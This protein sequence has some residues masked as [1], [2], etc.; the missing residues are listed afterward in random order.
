MSTLV[1]VALKIAFLLL[2][3]AFIFFVTMSVRTDMFG[4]TA[5]ASELGLIGTTPRRVSRRERKRLEAESV[6]NADE[7][8]E[9]Q[10]MII[11]GKAAGTSVPLEGDITLG[12]SADSTLYIDDDFASSRHA[13]LWQDTTGSWVVQDLHS[14]NGTL[15][16]GVRIDDPTRISLDDII[17]IGRT[18]LKLEV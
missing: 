5:T 4:R 16:N 3:W 2:M 10:L 18:Q 14:T 6:A 8:P 11:N 1:V 9:T 12:R 13:R 15:V 7:H 17:R